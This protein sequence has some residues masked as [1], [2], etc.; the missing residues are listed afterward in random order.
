MS[1]FYYVYILEC[2]DASFYTGVTNDLERRMKE[3][4]QGLNL[5]CYTYQKRPL[6]LV[7]KQE[8]TDVKQAIAF[9]KKLKG[10]RREKKIALINDD[11][12]NLKNI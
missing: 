12:E 3:H 7:F 4:H 9:E 5:S 1:Q 6:E 11:W 2:S 10:W 8:F